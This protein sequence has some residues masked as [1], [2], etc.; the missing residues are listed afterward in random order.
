M[1]GE[2]RAI[3][4]PVA[5]EPGLV[6]EGLFVP[7]REPGAGGAVVAAP[8]PL[9]GGSMDSPVVNELA[10][11]FVRAGRASL[12]FNW[13]GVGASGGAPSGRASEADADTA[14]ALDELAATVAG[15]LAVAGYSFG[16]A[17]A[18]RVGARAARVTHLLLVAPP[19]SLLDL[20]ALRE[21]PGHTL[22]VAAEEDAIAPADEL[23][24]QA[25]GA[26]RVRVV[27]IEEADHFFQSGLASLARVAGQWIARTVPGEDGEG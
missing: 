20:A 4:I 26:P 5:Q 6:L 3:V 10:H 17:A 12:R 24:A 16:A 22:L 13:R 8:H 21:F 9:Y 18:L 19:P 7:G 25:A 11:A 23:E 15:P 2:E 1:H 27:R 14:A